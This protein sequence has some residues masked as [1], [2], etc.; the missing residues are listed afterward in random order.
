VILHRNYV[1]ATAWEKLRIAAMMK[2]GC[3]VTMYRQD[4][5]KPEPVS[6]RGVPVR[7]T[8][9]CNH[10]VRDNKRMGHL[11]TIPMRSWY[12][13]GVVPSPATS[14]EEARAWYGAALTDGRKAFLAS[15][16]VDEIELWKYLQTLMGMSTDLPLSKILPRREALSE[17]EHLTTTTGE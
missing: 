14:K 7:G 11:Y 17:A 9:E 10:I 6:G 1:A 16:G 5:T 13:R 3:I 2:G 15:H 8:V 12:H 4:L